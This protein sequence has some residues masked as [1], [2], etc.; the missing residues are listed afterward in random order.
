MNTAIAIYSANAEVLTWQE[1][2]QYNAIFAQAD[3]VQPD[4]VIYTCTKCICIVLC[5]HGAAVANNPADTRLVASQYGHTL[6][7]M[8]H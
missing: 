5:C 1:Q 6:I 8:A 7:L 2:L 4:D 3:L